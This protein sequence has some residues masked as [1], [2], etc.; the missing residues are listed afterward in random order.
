MLPAVAKST[1][2]QTSTYLCMY[3]SGMNVRSCL[4]PEA[5]DL[6]VGLATCVP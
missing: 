1:S 5:Y 6:S 2:E 3:P 4:N